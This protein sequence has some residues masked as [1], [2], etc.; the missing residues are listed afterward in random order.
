MI[1]RDAIRELAAFE[2]PEGCA[3]SFYFQPTT[4]QNKSHRDEVIFVKDLVR[5][6]LRESEKLG[7]NGCARHDLQRILELSERLH[8]NHARAK[9]VFACGKSNF[10][11]EFDLPPRLAGS[12]LAVNQHFHLKPL[13]PVLEILPRICVC[14]L[15]RSKARLFE[16]ILDE[17]REPI[18]MFAELPR[19]G[20]S[21]GWGGYDA[22]HAERHIAHEAMHHFKAVADRLREMTENNGCDKV[23]IGCR[24]ETWPEIDP[25][26][27][28]YVRQRLLG[29]FVADPA[30][31][32]QESIRTQADRLMAEHRLNRMQGLIREISGEAHRNGRGA[33]GMRRVLRSMETGEVQTLLLGHNFS[34]VGSQCRNCG[35]L[36]TRMGQSCAVCGKETV[37]VEDVSDALLGAAIRNGIEVVYVPPDPEFEKAG[38]I[39]ALLRFRADQNTSAKV[40]S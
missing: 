36:D 9:A 20:R 12:R 7:K 31:A 22:G 40:A 21:D 5:N 27:H 6:A 15:D 37:E 10:W 24:D 25:H 30:T 23:V 4:P 11:R 3:L 1:T 13:A 14:V 19:R 29:R 28:P 32:N 26:L 18:D 8:G 17:V 2:S 33:L 35:H 16:Y 34:A 38:N 39:A